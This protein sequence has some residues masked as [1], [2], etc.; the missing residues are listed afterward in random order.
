ME[1]DETAEEPK[2]PDMQQFI[3]LLPGGIYIARDVRS[4]C[5]EAEAVLEVSRRIA[6]SGN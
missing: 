3:K 4:D 6:S 1:Y 2:L 5:R